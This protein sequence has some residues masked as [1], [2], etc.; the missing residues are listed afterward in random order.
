MGCSC[1]STVQY[2][3]GIWAVRSNKIT[4]FKVFNFFLGVGLVLRAFLSYL[5]LINLFFIVIK[6]LTF[7]Y[8]R[9]VINLLYQVLL[10]PLAQPSQQGSDLFE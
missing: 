5:N 8:T 10:I 1:W 7:M 3:I 9:F 6:L 2:A 4:S